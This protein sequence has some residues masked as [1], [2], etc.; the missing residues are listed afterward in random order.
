MQLSYNLIKSNSALESYKKKIETNYV[1]KEESLEENN[2]L[3]DRKSIE[4]EIRRSYEN[5]GANILRK[6]KIE[7]EELLMQSR[8]T[9]IEIEKT[10]Y[11]EGYAQGK[12]N[13]FEDGYNEGLQKV[14]LDTEDEVRENIKK[15][16]KILECANSEYKEYLQKK[17]KDIIK[18]AFEMASIIAK[19][20]LQVPDGILPLLEDVLNEAKGEENIIIKCN[21]IHIKAISDKVDYYKKAYAIKGE[22][23]ILEDPLIESGN[24][25]VEKNTGKA[26]IGLDI[27]LEKLEEALFK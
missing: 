1:R 3:E 22:I 18:L 4:D 26:M 2:Q 17:E 7:A 13:G 15:S 8:K 9:A 24:A 6:A 12:E 27:A 10:S 23:F 19:R 20:E 25:I 16:E 14:K 5:L 21:S 11:E